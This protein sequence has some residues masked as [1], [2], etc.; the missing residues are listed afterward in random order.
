LAS[1]LLDGDVNFSHIDTDILANPRYREARSKVEVILHEDWSKHY[2]GTPARLTIKTKDGR[3][4]SGERR[5][6]VGSTR[7]PYRCRN[8]RSYMLN[9]RRDITGRLDGEDG[10][11]DIKF[12]EA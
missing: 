11:A 1:A 10:G 8:S 6:P 4:F 5:Y 12:G 2:M 7:S 9:S 3:E